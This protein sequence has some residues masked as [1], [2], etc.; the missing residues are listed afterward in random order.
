MATFLQ[1]LFVGSQQ[2]GRMFSIFIFSLQPDLVKFSCEWLTFW[3]HCKIEKK[4]ERYKTF[5]L[6]KIWICFG[7]MWFSSVNWTNFADL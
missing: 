6:M 2:Y 7:K 3:L 4:K 5:I 1:K